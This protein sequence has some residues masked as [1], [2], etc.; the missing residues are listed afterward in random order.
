MKT[1]TYFAMTINNSVP[2]EWPGFFGVLTEGNIDS[3]VNWTE[4]EVATT[5]K[6]QGFTDYECMGKYYLIRDA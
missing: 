3:E 6:E 5:F 2:A 4:D 1:I